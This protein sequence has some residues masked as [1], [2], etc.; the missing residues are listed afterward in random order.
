M[1]AEEEVMVGLVREW[2]PHEKYGLWGALI[3]LA[4]DLNEWELVRQ[5]VYRVKVIKTKFVCV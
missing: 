1:C 2:S 5:Q 3:G 4:G